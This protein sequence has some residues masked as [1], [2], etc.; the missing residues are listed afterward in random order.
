[1]LGVVLAW[2][3]T[4]VI[5]RIG[6]WSARVKGRPRIELLRGLRQ[7]C[8]A[9]RKQPGFC[10]CQPWNVLDEVLSCIGPSDDS[11]IAKF[12]ADSVVL[13]AVWGRCELGGFMSF[14]LPTQ[15]LAIS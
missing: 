9:R 10:C 13:K 14:L 2:L 1:M 7:G 8:L 6:E 3:I 15:Q 11:A 12:I 5:I 4:R